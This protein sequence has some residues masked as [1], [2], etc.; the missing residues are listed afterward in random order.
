M[1][2]QERAK[3]DFLNTL[4]RLSYIKDK[5]RRKQ[6]IKKAKSLAEKIPEFKGWPKAKKFWD[7][8]SSA[9]NVKI[10][11]H[12]RRFIRKELLNR[13]KPGGLNLAL[14]SGSY[15][16]IK[17][18]VL[19]DYSEKMLEQVIVKCKKKVIHNIQKIPW[20][21]KDNQFDSITAV[22]IL[23]YLKN[24]MHVFK[25][26]R[27]VLKPMGKLIIVQ[28]AKQLGEFYRLA[29]AKSYKP[30]EIIKLSLIFR[31]GSSG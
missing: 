9:W 8:E 13:I 7:I 28:S 1:N 18:S 4:L 11:N 24:L 23:N 15:P 22:F 6:L 5:T 14:G 30:E 29:E 26:A 25:E 10:P 31:E 17:D 27:R 2:L 16:Y 19:V 12:V 21:F 3:E 20:P